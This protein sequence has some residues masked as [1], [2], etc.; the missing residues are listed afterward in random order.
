MNMR[1][2]VKQFN[3]LSHGFLR[4][5]NMLQKHKTLM[6]KLLNREFKL[7]LDTDEFI[8]VDGH[9][10]NN[11]SLK[12]IVI[13]YELKQPV[14][15][16]SFNGYKDCTFH[17]PLYRKNSEY[18]L[19]F[20]PKHSY[21]NIYYRYILATMLTFYHDVEIIYFSECTISRKLD[22]FLNKIVLPS[23]EVIDTKIFLKATKPRYSHINELANTGLDY[24][25]FQNDVTSEFS[26]QYFLNRYNKK[27][28]SKDMDI[29]LDI[30]K[31]FSDFENDLLVI[32]MS[33]I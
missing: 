33:M 6:A 17:T 28:I 30:K 16:S 14:Y 20:N 19:L 9:T 11:F 12:S 8:A 5:F 26:L 2:P 31:D 29:Q 4:E 15:F 13:N 10:V 7:S 27:V 25:I 21:F 18:A 22:S 3:E 32:S 23:Y 1:N 24:F